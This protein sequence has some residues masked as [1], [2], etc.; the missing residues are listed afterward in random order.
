[1]DLNEYFKKNCINITAWAQSHGISLRTIYNIKNGRAPTVEIAIRIVNAT[2]GEVDFQDLSDDL[3][4]Y[5]DY[6]SLVSKNKKM[7]KK[8]KDLALNARNHA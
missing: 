4:I 1:M 2:E 7:E 6:L 8:K 5:S 3:T